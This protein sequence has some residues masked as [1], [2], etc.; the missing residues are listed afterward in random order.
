MEKTDIV[1][2]PESELNDTV[3]LLGARSTHEFIRYF[4]ASSVALVFDVG[5]LWLFTHTLEIPYL[6]SGALAF[7]IGLVVVYALSIFWVFERRRV[8]NKKA[9]F[10]IFAAIGVFGLLINETT[11]WFFT[12]VLGLF[13]LL[14]KI[15]SIVVVFSWNYGARKMLLFREST[16]P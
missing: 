3:S 12:G 5:S 13:Y 7:L 9:E 2:S 1:T 11:L 14:S 4:A 16:L 15:I 8:E 6:V 10:L